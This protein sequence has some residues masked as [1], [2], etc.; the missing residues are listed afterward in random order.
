MFS[1]LLK[2]VEK[3]S[4]M[5]FDFIPIKPEQP[6]KMWT[7][8]ISTANILQISFKLFWN[9]LPKIVSDVR[10][11]FLQQTRKRIAQTFCHIWKL[12]NQNSHW[13]RLLDV[14]KSK[15]KKEHTHTHIDI[16]AKRKRKQPKLR[17]TRSS[18]HLFF[19]RYHRLLALSK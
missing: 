11:L 8:D 19:V 5:T 14:K 17:C 13:R 18:L 2:Y 10:R 9:S 3:I 1:I 6:Y 4:R 12:L 15:N 7:N 16:G